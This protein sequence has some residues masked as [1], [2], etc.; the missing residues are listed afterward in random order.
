MLLG[1]NSD[2]KYLLADIAVT[3]DPAILR[4]KRLSHDQLQIYQYATVWRNQGRFLN[5][6]SRLA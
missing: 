4:E 1:P 6:L 5:L 2:I 3:Q